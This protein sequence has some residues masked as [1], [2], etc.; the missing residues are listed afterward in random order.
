[1]M[2]HD[3][4]ITVDSEVGK[5]TGF[6]LYLPAEENVSADENISSSSGKRKH[7]IKARILIMDDESEIRNL[8][9]EMLRYLGHEAFAVADGDAAIEAYQKS[10]AEK[11]PFDLVIMDL[12]VPG[13][14]GGK[15]LIRHLL[16][17]DS[18]VRAIVSSGYSNDPVLA[19]FRDYGFMDLIAKPYH[20]DRLKEIL[21]NVLP[22]E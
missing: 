16:E 20:F 6:R 15:E 8:L 3:G 13:N 9:S 12:T 10:L 11:T 5:G 17:I 4:Y 21:C 14:M 7:I 2:H 18:G 19:N 1:M 22:C